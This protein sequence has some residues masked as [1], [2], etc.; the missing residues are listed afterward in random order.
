[1]TEKASR[2]KNTCNIAT[3]LKDAAA[4]N[5]RGI[6]VAVP[7]A[8][9][10]G[11]KMVYRE[12]SFSEL[13]R[14]SS[15]IASGLQKTGI[16]RGARTLLMVKPGIEFVALTFSLFKCGAVP[17][18]IDPGMGKDNLLNCVK[19][20][21]VKAFIGIRLAHLFR[22]A[23][24]RHFKSISQKISVGWF[25]GCLTLDGV[26]NKGDSDFEI[27]KTAS[28]ET[29]AIIFTTGSTGSP[30]GVT[31]THGIFKAQVD[32]IRDYYGMGHGDVDLAAFPLFALFSV[33]LGMKAVIPDMNPSKPAKA[34]PAKIVE[35]IID[36]GATF[37]FGSP[38]LWNNVSRYCVENKI[39]LPTLRKVLMAG[40]PVP[41]VIHENLLN[42]IMG[43]KGQTHTPYG[44]TESLPIADMTGSEV[45]DETAALT[46]KGKGICVGRPLPGITI[47]IIPITESVIEKFDEALELPPEEIGEIVVKGPVVTKE[48]FDLAEMT[49]KAKI[50]EGKTVWHR[51]GDVGYFDKNGRLW[52]CGRKGHRVVTGAMTL[53]T[54]CCEAIFNN[55]PD[56]FRGAL[57]GLGEWPNQH[58]VIIIEL[59]EDGKKNNRDKITKE[60]LESA[61]KNAITKSIK[62]V[63]YH[64]SFPTDIRHN[65]KIFR[66]ELKT[67]AEKKIPHLV[68]K[69]ASGKMKTLVL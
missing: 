15:L 6:A 49:Q 19:Q 56:V 42:K 22:I 37:S 9:G 14:Q 59:T 13:D 41:S 69:K 25:P 43:E 30:K 12:I 24:R 23:H 61:A 26:K 29:A 58:P 34:D 16:K 68:P 36:N 60:L 7:F 66:E 64:P 4:K 52:F 45:L 63:L 28:D 62:D 32:Y 67:W 20:V 17:V 46:A 2:K 55:H 33:G 31:Y 35:A 1:M 48:Y 40:A 54:I 10:A 44:A 50:K 53:F 3:T 27:V 39:K 5:P 8:R 65:A 11:G 18:F 47:R 51:M 21:S 57:V 38:A